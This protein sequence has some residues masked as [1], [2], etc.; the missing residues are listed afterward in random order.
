MAGT[1][2]ALLILRVAIWQ[3]V[4]GGLTKTQEKE[5]LALLTERLPVPHGICIHFG[6]STGID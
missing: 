2:L 4:C 5:G 6:R 1:G 3:R